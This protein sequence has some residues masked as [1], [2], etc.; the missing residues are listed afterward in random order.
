VDESLGQAFV[1]EVDTLA[2]NPLPHPVG[3]DR[4]GLG[5]AHQCGGSGGRASEVLHTRIDYFI[6]EFV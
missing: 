5:H 4:D 1:A 3:D 6:Q 2:P